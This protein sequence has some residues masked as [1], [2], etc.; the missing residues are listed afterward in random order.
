MYRA[1]QAQALMCNPYQW[2]A[3]YGYRSPFRQFLSPN[4][5]ILGNQSNFPPLLSTARLRTPPRIPC[6]RLHTHVAA[7]PRLANEAFIAKD[8]VRGFTFCTTKQSRRVM[9]REGYI[10][11]G[12][13]K[14]TRGV[15]NRLSRARNIAP[16]T[17]QGGSIIITCSVSII[18]IQAVVVT[19]CIAHRA[20]RKYFRTQNSDR[21]PKVRLPLTG[22]SLGKCFQ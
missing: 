9:V 18:L 19:P 21:G 13:G 20:E 2:W 7:Q 5:S 10:G 3:A 4:S 17:K 8:G 12:W 15:L 11:M 22:H 14:E 1:I 6:A 16:K